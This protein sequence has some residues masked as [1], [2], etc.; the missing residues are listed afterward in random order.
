MAGY[1]CVVTNCMADKSDTDTQ[2]STAN[3]MEIEESKSMQVVEYKGEV[4][5]LT[6][7]IPQ[8]SALYEEQ[9]KKV[10]KRLRMDELIRQFKLVGYYARIVKLSVLDKQIL[11][12]T[13]RK[14][15]QAFTELII[16]I[17]DL[18]SNFQASCQSAL[19]TMQAAV[20]YCKGKLF[21][22]A[23][24]NFSSIKSFSISMKTC[25]SEIQEMCSEEFDSFDKLYY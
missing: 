6:D 2:S 23:L 16:S 7:A 10:Y 5:C 18:L 11:H 17:T 12:I 20:Q 14:R 9:Y 22:D 24:K 19:E 21:D 1:T 4:Y 3:I 13:F 15:L 25:A 8:K